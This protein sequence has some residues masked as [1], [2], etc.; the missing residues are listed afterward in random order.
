M[1][2]LML[3]RPTRCCLVSRK[4]SQITIAR[5]FHARVSVTLKAGLSVPAKN[6]PTNTPTPLI[7]ATVVRR[8]HSGQIHSGLYGLQPLRCINTRAAV[9]AYL[10]N[11]RH[12]RILLRNINYL[13]LRRM[14]RS[15]SEVSMDAC[16]L[17]LAILL[18]NLRSAA[19][20]NDQAITEVDWT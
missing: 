8:I 9:I 16:T 5:P 13:V 7:I 3:Y 20:F 11:I 12:Q 18:R 1:K 15:R 6:L 17:T 19:I 4:P 2:S 14:S 10:T